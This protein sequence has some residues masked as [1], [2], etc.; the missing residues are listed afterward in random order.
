M[1]MPANETA[2]FAM[3][4]EA[5]LVVIAAIAVGAGVGDMQLAPAMATAQQTGKQSFAPAQR[6][7]AHRVLAIGV[8]RDQA[9]VPLVVCPAQITP[10]VIRD[11]HLPVLALLSEAAAPPSCGP[12]QC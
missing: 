7:A 6:T 4:D 3:I 12:P 5:T 1:R 8:V 10:V 2:I 9:Q 11:Q